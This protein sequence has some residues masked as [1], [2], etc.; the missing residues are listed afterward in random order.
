MAQYL[1]SS[2]NDTFSILVAYILIS[3]VINYEI[4]A[5]RPTIKYLRHL[6][7]CTHT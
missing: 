2:E 7:L 6:V 3:L 4:R 5:K 1:S